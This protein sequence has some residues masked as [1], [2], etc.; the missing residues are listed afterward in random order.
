M[1]RAALLALLLVPA[2]ACVRS[3][4]PVAAP[5]PIARGGLRISVDPNPIVAVPVSGGAY[6][7][8][9]TIRLNETGGAAVTI[10]RV[11]IDVLAVGGLKVYSTQLSAADIER[12]GYS[13][14]I[15]P[16]GEVRYTMRPRQQVPDE[17]IF[18]SVWAEL[19]AEGRDAGGHEITTR[20]RVTLTKATDD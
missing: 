18:T 13:R 3:P 11:G 4:A 16:L 9:F 20:T 17:R 2:A 1:R 15:E 12:R 6:E 14:T 8:P 19:W 10:Q 5:E 7:F